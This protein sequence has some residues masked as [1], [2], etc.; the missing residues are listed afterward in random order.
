MISK[1]TNRRS[2]SKKL[3]K[4]RKL[5][6]NV[7]SRKLSIKIGGAGGDAHDSETFTD[8]LVDEII[9]TTSLFNDK[10]GKRLKTIQGEF[11]KIITDTKNL[12][13]AQIIN[14]QEPGGIAAGK[15]APSVTYYFNHSRGKHQ[16]AVEHTIG[17]GNN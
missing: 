6:R 14:K 1:K 7:K 13:M 16:R 4:S 3:N 15:Q 10:L 9:K 5:S 11:S 2:N 8:A 17:T 12:T